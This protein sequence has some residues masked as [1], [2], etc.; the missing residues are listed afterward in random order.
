[1]EPVNSINHISLISANIDVIGGSFTAATYGALS[2]RLAPILS[3]LF[4]LYLIFWGLRFWQGVGNA[5][6]VTMAFRLLRVAIVF[7]VVSGWGSLQTQLYQALT[8]TPA[9]L[10][11]LMLQNIR[12]AGRNGMSER[13]IER[14]LNDFYRISLTAAVTVFNANRQRDEFPATAASSSEQRS[15]GNPSAPIVKPD[16]P[17]PDPLNS[18][19]R[20]PIEGGAIW[21]SSALFVGYAVFLI[22]YSK[23]ALLVMLALAPVFII[24]L[25]FRG[26]SRFF[27]GWLTATLQVM[28]VP[29]LLYAFL[30]FYLLSIRE[31]VVSIAAKLGGG[32]PFVMRDAAP[33]VL[34]CFIGLFLLSQ[35]ISLA[36]RIAA[37]ASEWAVGSVALRSEGWAQTMAISGSAKSGAPVRRM[38]L[39]GS[40]GQHSPGTGGALG[41]ADLQGRNA[42]A[43]R[44]A[45]NR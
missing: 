30:G 28:L 32:A 23:I 9:V 26:P 40:G 21:L 42:S 27:S 13:T 18:T 5:S 45:K 19:L 35:V 10:S 14:D 34:I 4:V 20:S 24:M 39:F 22:V 44:L 36:G 29:V 8:Q 25:L 17:D 2:T 16:A 38:G 7:A 6:V 1:M 15:A 41:V 37:H 12:T 31:P 43:T 33:F 11:S 3:A